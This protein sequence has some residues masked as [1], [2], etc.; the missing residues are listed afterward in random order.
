M[1]KVEI[2]IVTVSFNAAETI[3]QTLDSINKQSFKNWE[4][5]IIDGLSTDETSVIVGNNSDPRRIFLSEKDEGIYDAMNKGLYLAKGNYVIILNS[6]DRFANSN[7]LQNLYDIFVTKNCDVIYSGI[8][9]I[10]SAGKRLAKWIPEKFTKGSYVSGFHTPHPGFFVRRNLYEDLGQFDTNLKIA[11]DFD[12]M[13]R[14]MEAENIMLEHYA[15]VTVEQR[16]NGASAKLKN[17]IVGF[18][19]ILVAFKKAEMKVQPWTYAYLRY[20]KKILR[21]LVVLPRK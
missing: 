21:K 1:Q 5:I 3:K 7:V 18:N 16:T 9:F 4:H 12:L 13:L 10:D 14:F 15:V 17:I 11:A 6:D 2:S 8:A 20:S 19:D